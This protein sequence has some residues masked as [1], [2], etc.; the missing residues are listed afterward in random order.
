MEG[1]TQTSTAATTSTSNAH[2]EIQQSNV[3]V[4]PDDIQ[5]IGVENWANATVAA[6]KLYMSHLPEKKNK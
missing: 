3:N 4:L 1:N 2:E 6:E 5:N